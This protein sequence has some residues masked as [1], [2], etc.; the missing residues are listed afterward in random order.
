MKYYDGELHKGTIE[1]NARSRC[2]RK[3]DKHF[4]IDT[5]GRIWF[6]FS[7]KPGVTDCWVQLIDSVISG[8]QRLLI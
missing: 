6:L 2:T 1:L 5:N 7:N 4:E 3:T 8:M